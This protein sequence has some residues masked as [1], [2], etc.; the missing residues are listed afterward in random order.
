MV[1]FVRKVVINIKTALLLFPG[2]GAISF[3]ATL[4]AND[5]ATLAEQIESRQSHLQSLEYQLDRSH[6]GL[7]EPLIGLAR[8]HMAGNQFDEADAAVDRAIQ[9]VRMND[10]LF[11]PRQYDL[12]QLLV[13]IH[14]RRGNWSALNEDLEYI[15]WLYVENFDGSLTE[16]IQRLMWLSDFHMT[17]TFEDSE[18]R[19]I[20]HLKLATGLN[21]LA[22]DLVDS[23]PG[24][25][26]SLKT[27]L[28]YELV[29]KYHMETQGIR[30]GG[31]TSY[32]IREFL[33]G[34]TFVDNRKTGLRKRYVYG[35]RQLEEIRDAVKATDNDNAE[36]LAMINLHIADWNLL[37]NE[38]KDPAGDYELIYQSFVDAEVDNEV[39]YAAFAEPVLLPRPALFTDLASALAN[40]RV[41]SENTVSDSHLTLLEPS[42]NFPGVVRHPS[43]ASSRLNNPLTKWVSLRVSLDLDPGQKSSN[44]QNGSLRAHWGSGSNFNLA[45]KDAIEDELENAVLDRI[46]EVR[47]RPA[48]PNGVA[49]PCK[50]T[51]EY[52]IEVDR[53]KDPGSTD[54]PLLSQI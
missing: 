30:R 38:S 40:Q 42:V 20:A 17:A 3:S 46:H 1:S 43:S 21:K 41:A 25:P 33:P 27:G 39:L 51:V 36:A 12:L 53:N 50:L 24:V 14:H 11:T 45:R 7:T 4:L 49:R 19:Q 2:L 15:K 35:L 6:P 47:F 54:L 18:L 26:L 23:A 29:L 8:A 9:I 34:S 16:Q 28:K 13:E 32:K 22:V 10:G 52:L 48:M 31:S 5:F 37:F 44:W